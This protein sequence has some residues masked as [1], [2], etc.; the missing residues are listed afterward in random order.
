MQSAAAQV[1]EVESVYAFVAALHWTADL[2]DE[3]HQILARLS[4]LAWRLSLDSGPYSAAKQWRE[5]C[6]EHTLGQETVRDFLAISF[7]ARSK[8]LNWRF[9]AD[10]TVLLATCTLLERHRN[11]RP[12]EVAVNA[13]AAWSWISDHLAP[14]ARRDILFLRADACLSLGVALK[15]LGDLT[16]SSEWIEKARSEFASLPNS[17]VEVARAEFCAL[18]VAYERM[19]CG[20]ILAALPAIRAVFEQ[21]GADFEILNAQLLEGLSVKGLGRTE[22]A[23]RVLAALV[24]DERIAIN[25]MAHCLALV[26]L[27][28][29]RSGQDGLAEA[30]P[31]FEAAAA[32]AVD[33]DAPLITGFLLASYAECRRD[34]GCLEDAVDIYQR[35]IHVFSGAKLARLATYVRVI[36]AETLLGMGREA[37]AVDQLVKALPLIK[38]ENLSRE[39]T[40][41]VA[42]LVE[43]CRRQR[44]DKHALAQLRDQ[45][46]SLD[47]GGD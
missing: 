35:A 11:T 1:S 9:L 12:A 8:E 20:H 34:Q 3:R 13:F 10:P 36:L 21:N 30:A 2:F 15:H 32:K 46:R 14:N 41:A 43:S 28:E 16:E 25:P 33:L 4:Y 24:R 29:I 40:A 23:A 37:E 27:A 7:A 26:N 45:L 19:D 17:Q 44:L 38:A 5:R 42:L 47:K 6:V 18:A 31:L 39:G 22:D